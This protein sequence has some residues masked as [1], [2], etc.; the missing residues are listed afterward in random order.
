MMLEEDK[1][2]K[3]L[4]KREIRR[5]KGRH[6]VALPD[7]VKEYPK[8]FHSDIRSKRIVRDKIG[9]LEDQSGRL[10]MEPKE[11]GGDTKWFFCICIY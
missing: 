11:M 9:P 1:K 6:E 2:C 10:C 5:A 4:L 3:K 8:S 7:K